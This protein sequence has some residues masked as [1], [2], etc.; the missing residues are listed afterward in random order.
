MPE[1]GLVQRHRRLVISGLSVSCG[2]CGYGTLRSGRCEA[3]ARRCRVLADN[4]P[5]VV[6]AKKRRRGERKARVR[7]EKNNPPGG[8]G[9][10][11]TINACRIYS[12]GQTAHPN[13]AGTE[14]RDKGENGRLKYLVLCELDVNNRTAPRR[15]G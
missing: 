10:V 7:R 1:E 5:G 4:V 9:G 2:G 15:I 14:R 6:L 12:N 8:E 3:G 13:N 11:L